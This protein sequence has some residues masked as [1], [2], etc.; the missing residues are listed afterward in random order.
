[1]IAR[2]DIWKKVRFV[3][4][5]IML[6]TLFF[7]LFG[8]QPLSSLNTDSDATTS[9]SEAVINDK[10]AHANTI[11]TKETIPN[12]EISVTV[13]NGCGVEGAAGQASSSLQK[14]T[15]SPTVENAEIWVYDSW[16]V[17]RSESFEAQALQIKEELGIENTLCIEPSKG[18]W[19]YSSGILVVIGIDWVNA[20]MLEEG[21]DP[22][23]DN[24][25]P[26]E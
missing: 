2:W 15:F 23:P 17:Y 20:N 5:A 11:N 1:M 10:P 13:K 19:D 8:C 16:I 7:V 9:T 6:S 18:G 25:N 26:V 24:T 22:Y 21:Q 3:G 14:L 4:I 12:R